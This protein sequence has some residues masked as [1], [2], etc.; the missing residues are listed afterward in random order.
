[1]ALSIDQM[2][3]ESAVMKVIANFIEDQRKQ[4]GGTQGNKDWLLEYP[5]KF[6]KAV[7]RPD[8]VLWNS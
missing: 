7:E 4:L 5:E 8:D 6:I 2:R 3:K 1:M